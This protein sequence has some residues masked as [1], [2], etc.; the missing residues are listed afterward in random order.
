[1]KSNF[2]VKLSTLEV[3]STKNSYILR[4]SL[5]P[6]RVRLFETESGA[7]ADTM[8]LHINDLSGLDHMGKRIIASLRNQISE[9]QVYNLF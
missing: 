6:K 7:W 8:P 9:L 2:K 4:L 5:D 3:T 1:M